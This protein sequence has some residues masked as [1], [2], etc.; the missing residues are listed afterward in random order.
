MPSKEDDSQMVSSPEES[1]LEQTTTP[2]TQTSSPAETVLSPPDSQRRERSLPTASLANSNGKRPLQNI[3]NGSD[4]M[5][6]LHAMSNVNG[7]A[8]PDAP[9]KTHESSGY[10]YSKAEEE[11]GYAWLNKKAQDEFSR[12]W[13]GLQHKES[14]V[15]NQYGDPFEVA[16]KEKAIMASLKQQ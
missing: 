13:D 11:P 2:V 8:R 3:S 5:E 16:A 4:D 1:D 9:Y 10:T 7:K 14:M 15:K 12:A 6:E